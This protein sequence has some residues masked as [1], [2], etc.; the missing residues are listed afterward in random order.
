MNNALQLFNFQ[1][2]P[3]RVVMIDGEPWW[4]AADVCKVLGIANVSDAVEKLDEDEK[5]TIALTDAI[6]RQR[7]TLCINEHGLYGLVLTSRKPEAK[8]F[9]RWLKHEV[10]PSIRKTGSYSVAAVHKQ[11]P[12]TEE[13]EKLR[14]R[15]LKYLQPGYFSISQVVLEKL[16]Y[17]AMDGITPNER[18]KI[19]ISVGMFFSRWL[20]GDRS[21][22]LRACPLV[23]EHP[24]NR[25]K[26]MQVGHMVDSISGGFAKVYHYANLYLGDFSTFWESWY[27]PAIMPLYFNGKLPDGLPR[28]AFALQTVS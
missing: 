3:V 6:G 15:N 18:A 14:Q 13:A 12:W 7:S 9:K 10:L 21:G 1:D 22:Q 28:V 25:L 20:K 24:Y 5:D 19:D 27:V 23:P 16:I 11:F 26:V 8:V 17:V 4:V 2:Q